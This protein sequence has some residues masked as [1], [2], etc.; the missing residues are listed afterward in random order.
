MQFSF[1]KLLKLINQ[2]HFFG[3]KEILN[4]PFHGLPLMCLTKKSSHLFFIYIKFVPRQ[5]FE[6]KSF[7]I[8]QKDYAIMIEK[9]SKPK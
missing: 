5:L 7:W 6:V 2:D 9:S 1:Y 3:F 8:C 4:Y